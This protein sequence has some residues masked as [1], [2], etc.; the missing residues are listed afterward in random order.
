MTAPTLTPAGEATPGPSSRPAPQV[1]TP[2]D[3]ASLC[4]ENVALRSALM[5]RP[6]IAEEIRQQ[7]DIG[8]KSGKLLIALIDPG[9]RYRTDITQIHEARAL[10]K[11]APAMRDAL[12]AMVDL[13]EDRR[14][15][16]PDLFRNIAGTVL[17][18]RTAL[19]LAHGAAP[20]GGA[21]PQSGDEE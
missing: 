10:V 3:F 12:Q 2:D 5:A 14:S 13:F 9:M 1:A 8:M 7:W 16:D 15:D 17:K 20:A 21:N 18:A 4:E 19:A 11:S 6:A